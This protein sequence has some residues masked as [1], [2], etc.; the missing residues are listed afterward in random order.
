MT[1]HLPECLVPDFERGFW[2]CIC[3]NLRKCEDRVREDERSNNFTPDDHADAITEAFQRGLDA[4]REAVEAMDIHGCLPHRGPIGCNCI[5]P[6]VIA[7]IDALRK[8]GCKKAR[9]EAF[10]EA[11]RIIEKHR[12]SGYF[13]SCGAEIN[14]QEA[15]HSQMIRIAKDS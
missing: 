4:A 15:H 7:A 3:K 5:G 9:D 10:S 8:D 1:D 11:L 14:S 13:C 6:Q 2:I 12:I